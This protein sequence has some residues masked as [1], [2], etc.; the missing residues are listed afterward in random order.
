VGDDTIQASPAY[1][2][3]RDN[4]RETTSYTPPAY[5]AFPHPSPA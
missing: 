5:L 3:R 4:E 2:D 1:E